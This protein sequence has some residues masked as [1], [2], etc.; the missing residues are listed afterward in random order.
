MRGIVKGKESERRNVKKNEKRNVKES[1]KRNVKGNAKRN[2]K[3]IVR[4]SD[5]RSVTVRENVNAKKIV[6]ENEK[7]RRILR[8]INLR[9]SQTKHLGSKIVTRNLL[10]NLILGESRMTKGQVILNNHLEK[11]VSVT[12]RKRGKIKIL[13]LKRSLLG[14]ELI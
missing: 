7:R 3:R 6:K 13:L 4:G 10:S 1:E 12:K 2:G 8:M 9:G 14:G 5:K 11:S